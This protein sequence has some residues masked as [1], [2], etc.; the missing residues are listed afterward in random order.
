MRV[1]TF[2]DDSGEGSVMLRH[3]RARGIEVPTLRWQPLRLIGTLPCVV[4]RL[5]PDVLFCTEERHLAVAVAAKL[6]LGG[7]CPAVVAQ[8][9]HGLK[10]SR[11]SLLRRLGLRI[12][13][14]FVDHAVLAEPVANQLRAATGLP[15]EATTAI[16][17][18]GADEACLAAIAQ[19][20]A[21]Q[22]FSRGPT[23]VPIAPR[24]LSAQIGDAHS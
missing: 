12:A 2:L 6:L 17:S 24:R 20:Y 18:D 4:G 16:G 10:P 13:G 11:W 9:D 1:L 23:G 7:E 8:L 22:H 3:W 15:A 19:L 21:R 14:Q 5:Q